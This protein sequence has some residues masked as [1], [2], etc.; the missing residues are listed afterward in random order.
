LFERV[1][2]EGECLPAL[3]EILGIDEAPRHL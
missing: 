1:V 2:H 3:Q